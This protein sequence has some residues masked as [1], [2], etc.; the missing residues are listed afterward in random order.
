MPWWIKKLRERGFL[1]RDMYKRGKPQVVDKGGIAIIFVAAISFF[2]CIFLFRVL[3]RIII[4]LYPDMEGAESAST[5]PNQ[6]DYLIFLVISIYAIFGIL[7]DY[8]SIRY[9]YKI[10]IPFLFGLPFT[11]S[12][13]LDM[14]HT[15]F[16][17]LDLTQ[18]LLNI[19]GFGIITLAHA[20][21]YLVLPT[22]IMVAANLINM[23]AGYNGLMSGVST[24][25]ITFILIKA[26]IVTNLNNQ[27]TAI[28]LGSIAGFLYFNFYPAKIFEG[29]IGTMIIGASLGVLL[30]ANRFFISGC[31]LFIPHFVNFLLSPVYL[32][33]M[34]R[35]YPNDPYYNYR[36]FGKVDKKG[37]IHPPYPFAI[38]WI[39]PYFYKLNEKQ[40]TLIQYFITFIFGILFLLIP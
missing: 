35:L 21:K 20:A 15:P 31:I 14:W 6:S 39:P 18:T 9:R 2:L 25:M 34:A 17:N 16:G 26:I 19:P 40:C 27:F 29:N 4:S 7:D 11:T 30:V 23:H 36:K 24:I 10:L 12:M 37:F 13:Q 28:L 3:S 8:I 5:F 32:F 1:A 38:A 33:T 22:Y